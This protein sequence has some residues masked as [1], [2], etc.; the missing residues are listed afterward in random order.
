MIE[1]GTTGA[2]L[3]L[4]TEIGFILLVLTLGGALGGHWLDE[5]L[6][7]RFPVFLL[8]GLLLGMAAGALAIRRLINRFLATTND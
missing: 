2:Y 6:G 4:F 3:A 1:P 7:L 8:G 5:Q